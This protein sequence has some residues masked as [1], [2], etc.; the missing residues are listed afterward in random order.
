[1]TVDPGLYRNLEALTLVLSVLWGYVRYWSLHWIPSILKRIWEFWN[2]MEHHFV[3]V[4]KSEKE[5]SE[6]PSPWCSYSKLQHSDT[7]YLH[8]ESSCCSRRK[9]LK[10]Y[11]HRF[12]R[13]SGLHHWRDDQA[14]FLC[15]GQVPTAPP[16]CPPNLPNHGKTNLQLELY[17]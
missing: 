17:F 13:S 1:M 6:N 2:K 7:E 9:L 11:F 8:V 3:L 16:I 10:S 14:V 4:L 15:L 5:N 12:C